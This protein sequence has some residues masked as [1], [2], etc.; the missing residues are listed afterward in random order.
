MERGQI[1]SL[2]FIISMVAVIA[3]IGLMIQMVE[4]NVYSQKDARADE[5]MKMVAERAADLLVAGYKYNPSRSTACEEGG[6]YLMNCVK[7]NIPPEFTN[8]LIPDKYGYEITGLRG[9]SRGSFDSDNDFYEAVRTIKVG[10]T[11]GGAASNVEL[12]VKVWRA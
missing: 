12:K 10:N 9:Q 2:D 11:S 1:F 3:A 8:R 5:E 7:N 4:V 6:I